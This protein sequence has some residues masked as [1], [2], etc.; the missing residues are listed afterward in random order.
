VDEDVLDT[1]SRCTTRFRLFMSSTGQASGGFYQIM[2]A[3][4]HL[5]KTF[6]VRSEMCPHVDPALIAADRDNLKDSVFAIKHDAR[7]LYD[8]GDSM[9]SLEHVRAVI[10]KTAGDRSR[11]DQRLL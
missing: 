6:W 1:F 8:A 7:L 10:D 2:T 3:N 11:Q 9:I 4:S 5:W